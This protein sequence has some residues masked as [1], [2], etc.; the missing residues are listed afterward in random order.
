[1]ARLSPEVLER[2]SKAR[3]DFPTFVALIWKFSPLKHQRKWMR[4]LKRMVKGEIKE[5]LI[6]APRGSG[7]SALV[8][9]LFL[10]WMIGR[11][12]DK[13]YGLISYTDKIAYRR[14]RAIRNIIQYD[15]IFK[16][17]FP[18]LEPDF[19][20]WSRESFA[21]KREDS[22]DLHPTLI[23]AGSTSAIVSS[24][25][26]G[27]VYDDPH[28]EKNSKTPTKRREVVET[29]DTSIYFCLEKDAWTVCIAT[30]YADDDLPGI[31]ITRG[32][33]LIHQRA[34]TQSYYTK[35]KKRKEL[36]YAPELKPL[37]LLKKE[38]EKNPLVFALQMQGDTTGG[39]AAII[40]K[41]VTYQA[42][43]LPDLQELLIQAGTDTNYKDGE[44]ND[45][46]V[47]YV[48]GLDKK[49]NVW[50]LHREKGRWDVDEL[51]ELFIELHRFWHYSNNWIE[52]TAKGTPAVTV[53]K[54]KAA[55]VP[56]ELQAPSRGGKRS[57]ASSIASYLNSGQVKWP[58]NAAWFKDAEYYLTHYGHTDYDD[59]LDA[60][61]MFLSNILRC[62]HPQ[63]YGVGRPKRRVTIGGG[64][65]G[66]KIRRRR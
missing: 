41:L 25:L 12:P 18:G 4:E 40:R 29:Y 66:I 13:H 6:V 11:N 42:N 56:A 52:D 45:Y 10:T 26:H 21:L 43:E 48:G 61:F 30:R 34:I 3:D 59:D 62:I 51:A 15:P 38:Q 7:K 64:R 1:M 20:Q 63:N 37:A 53:L 9:V 28:D 19:R 27:L 57:R 60:L 54:K 46:I 24:R 39:K 22:T 2:V 58:S 32:F 16:L 55:F 36:S 65:K 31:F 47:I 44:A 8:G 35:T 50:M 14:S 33:T 49:G 23:A 5:L 17:I